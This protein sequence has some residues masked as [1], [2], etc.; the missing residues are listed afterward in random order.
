MDVEKTLTIAVRAQP[1]WESLLD[2]KVMGSCIPGMQSIEVLSDTEYLASIHVKLAFI[3][4]KFKMRTTIT[5]MR[6]PAYLRSESTGEDTSVASTLK[7]TTEVFVT[8][9]GD[10]QTELRIKVKVDL[11]G[12]LGTFGMNAM[13]T[14]A[15]RMW[16]EFARNLAAQLSG[17][18]APV[19]GETARTTTALPSPAE[20]ATASAATV[21]ES[22]AQRPVAG[23][24]AVAVSAS[25]LPSQATPRS[26]WQRLF[27]P[28][29]PSQELIHIEIRRADTQVFI[30]WPQTSSG[31][32]ASWLLDYLKKV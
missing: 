5:E 3:S 6:A 31:E 10:G 28:A 13:K 17:A 22:V 20:V 26:W 15:D 23:S 9:L 32:C 12:R 19:S 24:G 27:S 16:D 21:P 18:T 29:M 7:S 30:S 4:A 2:P 8:E 25:R 1:V 11:L 14:K